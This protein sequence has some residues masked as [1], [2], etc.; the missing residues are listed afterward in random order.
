M[1]THTEALPSR[2]RTKP[3]L[4][5]QIAPAP[6]LASALD[7]RPRDKA[8][9]ELTA[10]CMNPG[11]QWSTY[12]GRLDRS[13]ERS[14]IHGDMVAEFG[15]YLRAKPLGYTGRLFI[16]ED[17]PKTIFREIALAFPAWTGLPRR[18]LMLESPT[19]LGR[20]GTDH[21]VLG[22]DAVGPNEPGARPRP[23]TF[24]FSFYATYR[25][26]RMYRPADEPDVMSRQKAKDYRSERV[27]ARP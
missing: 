19:W 3:A 9:G 18:L 17:R 26:G 20:Y 23:P 8:S 24:S 12:F 13:F 4:S 16:L 27:E 11:R 5:A 7:P 2:T 25:N 14:L 15:H 6:T 1:Q 10:I 22:Q 21:P